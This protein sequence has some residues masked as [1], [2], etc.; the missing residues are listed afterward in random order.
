VTFYALGPNP[1]L[2][3]LWRCLDD[4]AGLSISSRRSA[5]ERRDLFIDSPLR[6]MSIEVSNPI[7][8]ERLFARVSQEFPDLTYYDADIPLSL[9]HAARYGTFP[10]ARLRLTADETGLVHELQTLDSPWELD[11]TPAPL[12]ILTIEP[13]CDPRRSAPTSLSIRCER[14]SCRLSLEPARPLLINL[15]AI[16]RRCDPDLIQTAWGD[17]WLLPYLLD[18][19]DSAGLPLPLNRDDRRDVLRK[20]EFT[21]FSYGQV[22]H[23][24]QQVL[25]FGRWHIDIFNAMMFHDYGLDGILESARVTSSPVQ[26]AARLSPGS[27]ISAMQMTTALRSDVLVPWH[28]QQAE[29]PK[30]A[31]ELIHADQ[32]GMVYQPTIGLHHD[33]AEIDFVSMYPSIMVYFNISPET[34]AGQT[35]ARLT[36][37]HPGD[38]A[39]RVPA[40]DLWIDQEKVGLIPRTLDPLL[41]KRISFK[42]RLV[43]MPKWDPR[44][45]QYQARSAAHKWLLVTCFGYL[46]YKNARFGRIEAHESVTA[47]SREAL[48]RAKEAAEDLGFEV[49]HMYVDGLWVR[50]PGCSQV[51]DFQPLLEQINLATHLPIALEGIYRWVAFLPSRVNPK[52]PVAN[53]YFGVFQ[54]GSLKVRGIEARRRD[55]PPFISQTQLHLLELMAQAAD[56]SHLREQPSQA[57]DASSRE[58]LPQ[59][60]DANLYR[61]QLTQAA[62]YLR[63]QLKRL[64]LGQ[65]PLEDLVVT[66]KLSRDLSL[67]HVRSPAGRAA[68]QLV[69]Q[70][71]TV[72]PGEGVRFIYTLGD[73]GVHAWDQL[74][75]LDPRRVDLDRYKT[76][77]LRASAA[78]LQPFGVDEQRLPLFLAERQL[79][80]LP[81]YRI[82]SSAPLPVWE[83]SLTP[84]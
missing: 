81:I 58:K 52:T 12:R 17:T 67:Y 83:F 28:K 61:E 38:Q 8:Q 79:T 36:A 46:G 66:Q 53:R 37:A 74:E 33:V 4:G 22:I 56:P 16:L 78:V 77:L 7:D 41:Q 40:L 11:P 21:Y 72:R 49:L 75:R 6:L 44:R 80:R 48:L 55:A 54:D 62:A 29:D 76:L 70:G 50:K 26:S 1:R 39:T 63:R 57:I 59:P 2:R 42:R 43:N 5:V 68:E 30:S 19:S 25:L 20:R 84:Y 15:A 3:E 18:L 32:G 13:D 14:F 24:G 35:A 65:V 23:R 60:S 34:V 82:S 73:P 71:K 47:Y 31:L 9:R 51:P 10:L 45:R 64:R 69:A 27:G